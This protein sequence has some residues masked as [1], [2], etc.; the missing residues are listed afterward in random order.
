MCARVELP[1]HTRYRLAGV[2]M[3][4]FADPQDSVRQPDLFGGAF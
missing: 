3:S 4:N 2:G 1:A